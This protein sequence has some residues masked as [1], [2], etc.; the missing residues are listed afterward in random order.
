MWLA[1]GE[2]GKIVSR[3]VDPNRNDSVTFNAAAA[4][5]PIVSGRVNTDDAA[6]GSTTPPSDTTLASIFLQRPTD[7]PIGGFVSPAVSVLIQ[8][9]AGNA[10]SG[11]AVTL[12]LAANPGGATPH[13]NAASPTAVG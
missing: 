2:T 3:V 9:E 8:D 6:A 1:P 5:A 12:A 7:T 11:A 13:N 10:K 4:V